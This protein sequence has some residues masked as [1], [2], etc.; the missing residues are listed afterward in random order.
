MLSLLAVTDT[1]PHRSRWKTRGRRLGT[2]VLRLVIVGLLLGWFYGWASPWAY[3]KDKKLGFP[4]GALHGALMPL[5]L[6][7]LVMG[8]DVSIFAANHNGRPYKIGYICG[9]NLCGLI[10]FG[11]AFA[12]H[13]RN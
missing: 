11:S 3:P 8:Q 13:R 2:V 7:S 6:P 4:Y 10:V 5:A 12:R 9:I 1:P